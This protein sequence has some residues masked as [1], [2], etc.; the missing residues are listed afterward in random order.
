MKAF[1]EFFRKSFF[2][3]KTPCIPLKQIWHFWTFFAPFMKKWWLSPCE[4][5]FLSGPFKHACRNKIFIKLK[6]TKYNIGSAVETL[7]IYRTLTGHDVQKKNA[8]CSICLINFTF[9]MCLETGSI[10]VRVAKSC[11][12]NSYILKHMD[13]RA[14]Y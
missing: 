3:K 6:K 13:S 11:P 8:I 4:F 7:A 1:W 5:W 2:D 10:E 14:Y 12:P 9:D